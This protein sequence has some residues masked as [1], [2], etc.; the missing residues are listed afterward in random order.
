[1]LFDNRYLSLRWSEA[2]RQSGC[3]HP[4]YKHL[5][6]HCP[7][8]HRG[9]DIQPLLSFT[10]QVSF[11]SCDKRSAGVPYVEFVPDSLRERASGLNSFCFSFIFLFF[12]VLVSFSIGNPTWF[13][14]RQFSRCENRDHL[15]LVGDLLKKY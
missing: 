12:K 13:L 14:T 15:P 1:M 9:N 5:N 2:T 4:L 7:D 6:C 8:G 3:K 11:S 10:L